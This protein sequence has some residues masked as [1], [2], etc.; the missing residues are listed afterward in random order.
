MVTIIA[1]VICLA[2]GFAVG[3]W[4]A[5]PTVGADEAQD[6]LDARL[7]LKANPSHTEPGDPRHGR[8]SQG[9]YH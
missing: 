6:V 8:P 9:Q 3:R 4:T 2:I 7:S 5:R 1:G